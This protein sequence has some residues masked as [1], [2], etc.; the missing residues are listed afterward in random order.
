M[1]LPAP[2]H[3]TGRIAASRTI[4]QSAQRRRWRLSNPEI[5]THP[6]SPSG[7]R[8]ADTFPLSK[9]GPAADAESVP[10]LKVNF[11]VGEF[12]PAGIEFGERAHV[13]SGAGPATVH[14]SWMAFENPP[15]SVIVMTSVA[16]LPAG[17]TRD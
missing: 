16:G 8:E 6:S 12:A 10:A 2:P 3:A 4:R 15:C 7:S 14:V 13:G 17:V 1:V 11:D 5:K 9:N